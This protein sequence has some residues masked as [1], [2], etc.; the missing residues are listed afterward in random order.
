MAE[1]AVTT[2]TDRILQAFISNDSG[3]SLAGILDTTNFN[4]APLLF[5]VTVDLLNE[6]NNGFFDD[7]LEFLGPISYRLLDGACDGFT[8]LNAYWTVRETIHAMIAARCS[9]ASIPLAWMGSLDN[10]AQ[11]SMS[12]T[13]VALSDKNKAPN[14]SRVVSPD[15]DKGQV[16]ALIQT[17]TL[18]DWSKALVIHTDTPYAKDLATSFLEHWNGDV[19]YL[20]NVKLNTDGSI[21]EESAKRALEEAPHNDPRNNS[22]VVVLLGHDQHSFPILKIAKDI[23]PKETFYVGPQ[24]W[25]GRSP[26]GN[27]DW[28]SDEHWLGVIPYRN[29][30]RVYQKFMELGGDRLAP[31]LN[32]DGELPDYAAEYT[33]DSIIA[34]AL[35]LARTPSN[36]R[37]DGARVSTELRK[38]EFPGVSGPVS[39]TNEGDRKDP[40]FSILN[41]Q[42]RGDG[43][44]W[45][46]VGVTGTEAGSARFGPGGIQGVC[47]AGVGCGLDAPPD[48]TWPI[49]LPPY[50][51]WVPSVLTL[52][53]A[54]GLA[55]FCYYRRKKNAKARKQKEKIAAQ[56]AE[57][58]G[59]RNSVVDMCTAEEQ[60]VPKITESGRMSIVAAKPHSNA[61]WCWEETDGYMDQWADSEILGDR[62]DRWVKYDVSSN[63]IL[64]LTYQEQG[65]S[66]N[67][68]PKDGYTVDFGKMIQIKDETNFTR[69]VKRVEVPRQE[70]PL[71]LSQ[72]FVANTIPSDIAKDPQL[73]LVP[74]DIV[75]ISNKRKDGWSYGSKLH[76]EDEP[77]GR[78]LV[79]L[80]LAKQENLSLAQK[81]KKAVNA[82]VGVDDGEGEDEE[83]KHIVTYNNGWFPTNVTRVPNKDDLDTLRTALGAADDLSAPPH[84]DKIKDPSVVQK[85]KPLKK[86]SPEYQQVATSFLSTLP[87]KTQILSIERIQNLAQL[88]TFIVKR[89]TILARDKSLVGGKRTSISRFERKW[90]WHGTNEDAVEKIIQQGF[91]RNFCGKNATMYG[92]GVYFA[93]DA[94]YSAY[95]TY[96]PENSSGHKF[97]LACNVVVGEYCQGKKDARTPDL[98]DAAK[99]ILY[100]STVDNV[101]NP[102][103]Y[104]TYHDAQA[105]PEYLIRFKE[106]RKSRS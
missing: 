57:L 7:E 19:P 4:W 11:I 77:L 3:V 30:D 41:Y 99:N 15:N 56:E 48:G 87:K 32:S 58:D 105:L 44:R 35:A 39:F 83:D 26:A 5:R 25:V 33:V 59:F 40:Q 47:F 75:Q 2:E 31:I 93:R 64:E 61:V 82:Y 63:Q 91:N 76:M 29:R 28:I 94:K 68:V 42:K 88:Q 51:V 104:V 73:V 101:S 70:Q 38:L 65:Q 9:G 34:M 52:S 96:S 97:I 84:W 72:I 22:K 27:T 50:K 10:K 102:E 55:G 1:I 18:L 100:D 23:F 62:A 53:F 71:D 14:F 66:G 13:S 24:A 46:D 79:Q 8:A 95:E 92:K 103:L 12:S 43:Y 85:S 45:I 17:I 89:N 54:G 98:R 21:D 6:K 60:Y 37:S 67:C 78:R 86:S 20:A 106:G 81:A 90:L 80:T 69:H 49:P 74:G 16:G 36:L